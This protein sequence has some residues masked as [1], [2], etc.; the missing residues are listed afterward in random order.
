L[1]NSKVLT[2]SLN[3]FPSLK[4]ATPEQRENWELSG[5]GMGVHWEDIDEDLS[6]KGFIKFYIKKTKSFIAENEAAVV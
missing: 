6:V 3:D 2:F 1:R 4:K 5:G